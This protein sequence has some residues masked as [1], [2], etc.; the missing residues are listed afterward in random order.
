LKVAELI[1]RQA[2]NAVE[3]KEIVAALRAGWWLPAVG[4]VFGG[5]LA[6]VVS[7]L[8]TPLYTSTTQFFVSTTG[9]SSAGEALQGGQFSEQR[10]AS[11]AE[12]LKGDELAALVVDR[13]DLNRTPEQ[14]TEQITVAALPDTVLINVSVE[15]PSPRRAQQIADTLGE[16]F[17]GLVTQLE[18]PDATGAAP[19]QV[20]V[21]NAPRIAE[22]PSSPDTVRNTA[23]G[24]LAGLLLGAGLALA[25]ARFD[26]SVKDPDEAAVL[27]GAP[28]IGVV[29]R[30]D[31][32]ATEH[33]V[34]RNGGSRAAED[35]RQ[36][37]ANLQFLSVDEPPKVIMV[38]SALPSEGKSTAVVNLGLALATAGRRVAIVEADLRRPKVTQYLG[39]VGGI[40][41]TNV[42]SGSADVEDVLQPVGEGRLSVIGAGPTPPNPGELLASGQMAALVEKLRADND[43]VLVDAPP[44][45]PVADAT[46][47]AVIV[48]GV[49][50]SVHYGTTRKEHLQQAAATLHGVGARPLGVILN[51][52]PARAP[53]A[54][55]SGRSERYGYGALVQSSS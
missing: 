30:D 7:A 29:L 43:Y 5:V 39:L 12:L 48:D 27:A 19:V 9:S 36:L 22:S 17:A 31:S 46:G 23:A 38:S 24:V 16:E 53:L 13:L 8:S 32:L 10:A 45:L 33:T 37:R 11:Y 3:L 26:R 35:Y 20:T 2:G 42:L 34:D 15:D 21:T 55:V 1:L 51:M 40:G 28:V 54:L 4:L 6:V 47:L 41:L 49:L 52:V 25:R 14:L 18:K 50:L 44:L